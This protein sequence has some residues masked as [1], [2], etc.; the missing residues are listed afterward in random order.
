MSDAPQVDGAFWLER[1]RE[2]ADIVYAVRQDR[3]DESFIKRRGTDLFYKLMNF[4]DRFDVP[5]GAGD[6]WSLTAAR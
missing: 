3:S 5:P 6:P 2:G 1:W 4:G